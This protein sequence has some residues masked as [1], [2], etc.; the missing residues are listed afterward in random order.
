VST[1]I[2]VVATPASDIKTV[3]GAITVDDLTLAPAGLHWPEHRDIHDRIGVV[4]RLVV[5][6][7]VLRDELVAECRADES[8]PLDTYLAGQ[9]LTGWAPG[10]VT[11]VYG[12]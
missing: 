2:H 8:S 4:D 9:P 6:L 3:A 1:K 11:E 10:E 12:K 7:Q 5:A